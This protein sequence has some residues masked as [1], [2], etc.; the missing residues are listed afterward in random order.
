[1]GRRGLDDGPESMARLSVSAS[2]TSHDLRRLAK[3]HLVVWRNLRH[4]CLCGHHRMGTPSWR[5]GRDL[6]IQPSTLL[7]TVRGGYGSR[8]RPEGNAPLG[9]RGAKWQ[10]D[11][12]GFL[13]AA[14]RRSA[15]APATR[16]LPESYCPSTP[17]TVSIRLNVYEKKDGA[18]IQ[19]QEI[20]PANWTVS[21]ISHGGQFDAGSRTISWGPWTAND[22]YSRS[23]TYQTTPSQ[24]STGVKRFQGNLVDETAATKPILGSSAISMLCGDFHPA[25]ANRNN[26]IS[27]T[28]KNQHLPELAQ[29]PVQLH[30]LRNRGRT[31]L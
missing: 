8:H 1:M 2:G 5:D 10:P 28:E 31:T 11:H 21:Q 6:C 17:F 22:L 9:R 23:M 18:S 15:S 16:S 29:W 14:H 30:S 12:D 7:G 13:E 25:D 27:L 20:V 4:G 3:Q 24:S 19:V 26:S